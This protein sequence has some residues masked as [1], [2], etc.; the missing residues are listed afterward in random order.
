M[1]ID[2]VTLAVELVALFFAVAFGVQLAQRRVGSDRLQSWLGGPPLVA[3][4]KGIAIGFIT[5]FCTF[6]AVPLL[7]G[8]RQAQVRTAGY[9]AFIIAAPVLDPVLFGALALIAGIPAALIYTGVAFAAACA[10]ALLADTAGIDGHLKPVPA[11]GP[12]PCGEADDGGTWQGLRSESRTAARAA[13]ALL[14][15]VVVVLALGVA[16]GLAI[17]TFV[18]PDM[19]ARLTGTDHLLS[20]P[21]AAVLGTPLY[22]GTALFVPIAD[23]LLAAGVGIGA[24]VALTISGT[25]ASVPEFL[26]LTTVADVRILSVF[27]GYV[28]VVAVGGG[29]IAQI[30]LG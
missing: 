11:C 10:L 7:I 8:L 29:L 13:T 30:V 16:I 25:G 18:S 22:L 9:V 20:I 19:T 28:L 3:A 1:I 23:A 6:S 27:F 4:L 14:R 5:P 17:E 15:S 26:L 21:A 12:Q 24:I 2:T